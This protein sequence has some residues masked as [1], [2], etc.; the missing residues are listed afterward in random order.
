M[1]LVPHAS[2]IRSIMYAQVCTRP[3]LEFITGMLVRYQK[4]PSIDH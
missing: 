4:N 1:K 2:A 3:D